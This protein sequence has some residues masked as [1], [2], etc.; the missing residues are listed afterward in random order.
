MHALHDKLEYRGR[1]NTYRRIAN[2]YWWE[3]MHDDVK[4]YVQTCEIY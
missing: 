1:K 2:K 3:D 4:K